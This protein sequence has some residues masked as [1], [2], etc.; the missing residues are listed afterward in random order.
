MT[1]TKSASSYIF[2]LLNILYFFAFPLTGMAAAPVPAPPEIS[3]KG[4]LILDFHSGAVLADKDADTRMEPA[5]ITKLMSAYIILEEMGK[6]KL[7]MQDMVR[8]SEKAWRMKG[9]RT[10]VEVGNQV[11]VETLLKGI[12]VQSGNDATVAMAEH[13]AGSEDAF[14]ALMNHKAAAL[15]LTSSHFANSTGWP[16]PDHYSTAR[17]IATLARAMIRDF[18]EHYAM[19]AEKVFSYN[20]IKQYNRNK[21]LWRDDSVDGIK[22]GHTESAGYCLVSSAKRDDMRLITVVLGDKSE[23]ARAVSSKA[24]LD[25]GFRFFKTRKLYAAGEPLKSVRIWKGEQENLSLGLT[26]PLYVTFPNGMYNQLVVTTS[27]PPQI[28]APASKHQRIGTLNVSLESKVV[29]ERPMV[30][31]NAV[32]EGSLWNRVSDSVLLWFE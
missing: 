26:E 23:D 7:G 25:Y 2:I 27:T 19:Y 18:P 5:S 16:D 20:G 11:T 12:I 14:V 6:G 4:Y 30:A 10:F 29:A 1:S 21:L 17:D 9:S 24:L 28:T 13:V 8:I 3:G 31:L 32:D 22:T 15:G